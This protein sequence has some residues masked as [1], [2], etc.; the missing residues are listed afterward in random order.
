MTYC[1]S[2]VQLLRLGMQK[3]RELFL[4]LQKSDGKY[5]GVDP[6][7]QITIPLV[8]FDGIYM[9][10]F[11]PE[12]T[13]ISVPRPSADIHSFKSILW[14]EYVVQNFVQHARNLGEYEVT[15]PNSKRV[16]V[17]G[18]CA[19]TNTVH[20]FHGCFFHGC[21]CCYKVDAP[22]PHRFRTSINTN[23]KEVQTPIKSG[24]LHTH[25]SDVLMDPTSW[26]Q[27]CRNVG[28]SVGYWH[29]ENED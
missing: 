14:L 19:V 3:F 13:L 28:M 22:T 27:V 25:I 12:Q 17:N 26:I 10:Y 5:I 8:A 6:D 21:C 16:K 1:H 24:E 7:N 29:E 11:L 9:K 18:Y 20:Q 2:D 23:G 4:N 15:L